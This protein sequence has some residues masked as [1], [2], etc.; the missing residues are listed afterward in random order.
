MLN[1]RVVLGKDVLV[2]MFAIVALEDVQGEVLGEGRVVVH[3]VVLRARD[4]VAHGPDGVAVVGANGGHV[5]SQHGVQHL[6]EYLRR[7]GSCMSSPWCTPRL[8]L[9][10]LGGGGGG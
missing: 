1:V 3:E 4:V 5:H 8:L 7:A 9:P 10:C 6:Y 2:G